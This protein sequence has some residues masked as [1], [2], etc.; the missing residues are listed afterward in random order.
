MNVCS[1][2]GL[3][4][5]V[6]ILSRR[7]EASKRR[8]RRQMGLVRFWWWKWVGHKAGLRRSWRVWDRERVREGCGPDSVAMY[9]EAI[10]R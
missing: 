9:L 1:A 5:V 7:E 8:A 2:T 4:M 10:S 3:F 6:W